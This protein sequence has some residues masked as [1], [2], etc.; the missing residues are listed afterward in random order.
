M[1]I[2][3]QEYGYN[4]LRVYFSHRHSRPNIFQF[5]PDTEFSALTL[6][7]LQF[8]SSLRPPTL[9]VDVLVPRSFD[10]F[11]SILFI[12]DRSNTGRDPIV[13]F[14]FRLFNTEPLRASYWATLWFLSLYAWNDHH[15]HHPPLGK[16]Y[17]RRM[18]DRPKMDH[19][20][21]LSLSLS[22]SQTWNKKNTVLIRSFV[23]SLD[24]SNRS[25]DRSARIRYFFRVTNNETD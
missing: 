1:A 17:L 9:Q 11:P 24:R 12:L 6:T 10:L 23:R 16:K 8:F 21:S 19:S 18:L 25:T 5:P 22:F 2:V 20:L 15:H 3:K 13:H 7:K 14:R 4:N